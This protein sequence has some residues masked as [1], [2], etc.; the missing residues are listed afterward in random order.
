MLLSLVLFAMGAQSWALSS[1]CNR[2]QWMKFSVTSWRNESGH[3]L[4][5]ADVLSHTTD[6]DSVS[7]AVELLTEKCG[8]S[9]AVIL[10]TLSSAGQPEE[11][12][13]VS[14]TVPPTVVPLPGYR[15]IPGLGYY[16]TLQNRMT[17]NEGVEACRKEGTHMLLVETQEEIDTLFEWVVCCSWVGVHR[18][19]SSGPWINVLGQRMNSTD[20]FGWLP[21]YPKGEDNCMRLGYLQDP[22]SLKGTV[23]Y[24][25]QNSQWV[26]CEQML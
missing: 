13:S 12:A 7:L 2:S 6:K 18:E 5:A 9:K 15:H 4:V 25:C 10:Q 8:D 26:V 23:N 16:K 14:S 1:Q 24:G 19:S 17:W 20:F 21:F 22:P 3:R 11:Q